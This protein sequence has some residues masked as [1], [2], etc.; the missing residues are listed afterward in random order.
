MSGKP[1]TERAIQPLGFLLWT[2]VFLACDNSMEPA[3]HDL[4]PQAAI[5]A[6]YAIQDLGN[7]PGG[8]DAQALAINDSGVIAGQSE[9]G[10][11]RVVRN[12]AF[13]WQ[14]GIMSDLGVLQG[15]ITSAAQGINNAGVIVGVSRNS[16]GG[17]RAFRWTLATGMV[18]LPGAR[19]FANDINQNGTIVGRFTNLAGRLHAVRWKNGVRADIHP[20]GKLESEARHPPPAPRSWAGLGPE[21]GSARLS[22]AGQRDDS[23]SGSR[24]R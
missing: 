4:V 10:V 14:A 21:W 23:G 7:L 19:S 15:D 20:V 11:G 5:T 16:M 3:V 12:H 1:I 9:V 18:A 22:L 6:P 8:Q 17:S 13:R 24:P 2:T